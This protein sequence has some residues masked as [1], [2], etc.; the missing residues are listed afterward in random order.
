M[1]C[2]HDLIG[3]LIGF[4]L[5]CSYPD[6]ITFYLLKMIGQEPAFQAQMR[7]FLVFVQV[8]FNGLLVA[9]IIWFMFRQIQGNGNKA[10][11]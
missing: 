2:G 5:L 8:N 10:F 7:M 11:S 3:I 1:C 9:F 6:Y 4:H